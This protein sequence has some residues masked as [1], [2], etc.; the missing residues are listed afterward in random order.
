MNAE[1]LP[2]EAMFCQMHKLSFTIETYID[3]QLSYK[4]IQLEKAVEISYF[5]AV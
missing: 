5:P 2:G 1:K 3:K 4:L